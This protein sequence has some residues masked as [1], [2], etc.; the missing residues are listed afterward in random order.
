VDQ[1]YQPTYRSAPDGF[2]VPVQLRVE[3]SENSEKLD[4][5]AAGV[6]QL[7]DIIQ[8]LRRHFSQHR[9]QKD[10][11]DGLPAR[12]DHVTFQRDEGRF[13]R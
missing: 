6:E 1:C 12:Q 11:G 8:H 5:A 10:I 4:T 9:V 2:H 3:R 13:P 7:G